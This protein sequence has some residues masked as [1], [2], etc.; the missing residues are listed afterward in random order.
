[1]K[2]SAKKMNNWRH[3]LWLL[4]PPQLSH[5]LAPSALKVYTYFFKTEPFKWKPLNWRGLYFPNR[6]GIAGG[7]D[8]TAHNIPTWWKLG[9]GFVEVGTV[10]PQKQKINSGRVLLRDI[11]NQALWNKMGFPSPGAEVIQK[12]LQALKGPRLTPLFINIGKNR[13][14]TNEKAHE[15][16][17]HLVEFFQEEAEAFVINISSPNTKNLRSLQEAEALHQLVTQCQKKNKKKIPLL[18]KFSPDMD[19]EKLKDNLQASI[20]AHVDGWILTNTTSSRANETSHLPKEGGVS[21]GPLTKLSR[22]KLEETVDILGS[23]KKDRL[24]VSAGGIL[25]SEEVQL[26]LE[27]GADLVQ[28]YS[29]LILKGPSFFKQVHDALS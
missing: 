7:V 25:S 23:Q 26:R 16:Y 8:K 4:L 11:N 9:C 12:K 10:T 5:D 19:K 22:Q 1:M 29:A 21:G 2:F 18:I 13:N 28:V 27:M 3:P 24:L 20:E 17:S 15:D 14:T 6:L